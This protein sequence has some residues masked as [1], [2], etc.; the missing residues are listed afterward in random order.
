MKSDE[1]SVWPCPV[2][3]GSFLQQMR[4]PVKEESPAGDGKPN[5]RLAPAMFV[6]MILKNPV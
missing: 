1:V 2:R 4:L 5:P 6:V 3:I